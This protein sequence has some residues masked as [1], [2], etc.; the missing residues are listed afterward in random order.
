M[1][2]TVPL[3]LLCAV[4]LHGQQKKELPQPRVVTPGALPGAP[5]SDAIILVGEGTGVDGW[6][7]PTD[8]PQVAARKTT[9]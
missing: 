3:L 9:R 4:F 5:P 8:R 2:S 6:T 7:N 1:K